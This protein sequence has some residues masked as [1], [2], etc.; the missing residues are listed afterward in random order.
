MKLSQAQPISSLEEL[1]AH[2]QYAIGIELTTIPA[3]LCALYS[4]E[5]G[6][7]TAA[8]ETIQSVVLEEMLHMALAANVLNAIGGAPSTGPV[9][10]DG[11]SPIPVYPTKVPFIARIPEIHLARFA[12]ETID[13]FIA[14]E[15]PG[16]EGDGTG[17]GYDSIGTFYEAIERGLR[18]L[19]TEKVFAEARET[20]KGCQLLPRHYYGG[21]GRLTEVKDLDS[22]LEAIDEIVR[23]GEGAPEEILGRAINEQV[24]GDVVEM[25]MTGVPPAYS[26]DDLDRLP[27][28]WKMYSHY[29]RFKEI[30][31][32][33]RYFP[34]QLVGDRPQGDILPIDWS[35]VLPMVTDPKAGDFE[36]TAAHEPMAACNETY[37]KLVDM[38]YASF[39][40]DPDL[41]ERAVHVMYE[42]K[43]QATALM[44]VPSPLDPK[45]TLGPAFEYRPGAA[46][47]A[48]TKASEARSL[49]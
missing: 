4:I 24:S 21:A 15:L 11:P 40:G 7:N 1:R 35:A 14:I 12:P 13:T 37:T 20:R 32:G 16:G 42:L 6:E 25:E 19:C 48:A 2:L 26:V 8:V 47:A 41:L 27:F 3:Y 43:Y 23:E 31:E 46:S 17:D 45:M 30:R 38:L 10:G 9:D 28:G 36:K 18:D 49:R 34:T 5:E 33:R 29:A 22:A 39:N 44:H